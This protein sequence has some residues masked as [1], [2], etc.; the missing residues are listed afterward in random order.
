MISNLN[1]WVDSDI[2]I[3]R[4]GINPTPTILCFGSITVGAGFTPAR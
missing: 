3:L 1:S 4:V 2:L